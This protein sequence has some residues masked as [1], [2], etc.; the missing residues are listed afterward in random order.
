MQRIAMTHALRFALVVTAIATLGGTARAD[1]APPET[2]PCV[3]KQVGDSCTYNGAGTC[4]SSTCSKLDYLN[5]DRDASASP[6]VTT[7]ACVKCL[8]AATATQSATA[9]GTGSPT[10][11]A[12]HTATQSA[13]ATGTGSPTDTATD[14]ATQSTTATGTGSPTDT[15]TG[16]AT[17]TGTGP[18]TDDKSKDDEGWCA[19]GGKLTVKRLGPWLMA[20]AF[21]L[22]FLL[23]RRR[24]R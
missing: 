19:I 3:G 23:G 4:Q 15:S 6:P 22:L 10:D 2:S 13:T 20:G 9:T 18:Q 17:H 7:Y 21:S 16:S 1:V 8:P 12:T 11:T 5:W 24:R 14:T